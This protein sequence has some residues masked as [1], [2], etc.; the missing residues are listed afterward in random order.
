DAVL[1]ASAQCRRRAYPGSIGGR[2]G[3]PTGGVEE[4]AKGADR[5]HRGGRPGRH[6]GV[7]D[8]R[9]ERAQGGGRGSQS[10]P[11]A[12]SDIQASSVEVVVRAPRGLPPL[13][14]T[15]KSAF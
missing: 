14:A 12:I 4:H 8:R 5:D 1:V 11:A 2:C 6:S 7:A 13:K 15:W 10:V 3:P 9:R